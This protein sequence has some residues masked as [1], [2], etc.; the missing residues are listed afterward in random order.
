MA[1]YWTIKKDDNIEDIKT[2]KPFEE[3]QVNAN[4]Q[5]FPP[6]IDFSNITENSKT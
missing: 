2:I 4:V 5:Q 6:K 3:S 1:A